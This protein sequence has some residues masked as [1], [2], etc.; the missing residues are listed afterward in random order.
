M[1]VTNNSDQG[2]FA[3]GEVNITR[4]L[5]WRY[6][7]STTFLYAPGSEG[8]TIEVVMTK[9][10]REGS[11][12]DP[13]LIVTMKTARMSSYNMAQTDHFQTNHST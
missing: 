12:A 3:L 1:L 8:K 11:G 9:P 6:S 4:D 7:T 13:Y 2:M 5:I 10:N